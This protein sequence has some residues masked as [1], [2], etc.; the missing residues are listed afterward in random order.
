MKNQKTESAELMVDAGVRVRPLIE[1][2][3]YF[4]D[5]WPD[6]ELTEDFF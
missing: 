3:M 2:E 6:A 4:E 5:D 1:D